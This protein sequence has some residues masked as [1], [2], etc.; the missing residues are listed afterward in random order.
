MEVLIHAF[1]FSRLD[2]CN[3]LYIGVSHSTLNRLQGVQNAA[4]RLLTGTRK[5][6]HISP[7][8]DSLGWLPI[9]LRVDFK[10]LCF[11]YKCLNG[12]APSYLSVLVKVYEPPRSLRSG[13]KGTL[14]IPRSKLKRRGDR[15]FS[16]AAPWLWNS[17]PLQIRSAPTFGSFKNYLKIH[18]LSKSLWVEIDDF[19]MCV[20][21]VYYF[22][23]FYYD[24]FLYDA[25]LYVFIFIVVWL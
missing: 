25:L 14:C 22:V 4:A 6:D 8:L 5:F 11:V 24:M 10:L 17:L 20:F 16:V 7:I 1:V 19:Y 3:S 21:P 2:Y 13:K 23:M 12:V 15:A 9:S 18:L